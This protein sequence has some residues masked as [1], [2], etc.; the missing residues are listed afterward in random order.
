MRTEIQTQDYNLILTELKEIR[1]KKSIYNLK[2]ISKKYS[3]YIQKRA[4]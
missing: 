1:K 2:S 4:L 3:K